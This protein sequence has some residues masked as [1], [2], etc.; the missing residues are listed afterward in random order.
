MISN[1][2]E[3]KIHL[4]LERTGANKV[5]SIINNS[6]YLFL[7][8]NLVQENKKYMEIKTKPGDT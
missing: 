8:I 1:Y 2:Q 5:Y 4:E 7:L 6:K 3:D